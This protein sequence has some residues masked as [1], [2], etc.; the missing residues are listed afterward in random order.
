M[1]LFRRDDGTHV[2]MNLDIHEL[3]E[4]VVANRIVLDD[5]TEAVRDQAEELR[6]E[7]KAHDRTQRRKL[8]KW[9]MTSW[10]AAINPEDVDKTREYD[11]AH[12]VPTDYNKH[13]EPIFTSQKHRANYCRVH[14]L[15]DRNAGYGDPAPRNR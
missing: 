8:A 13:G 1:Q 2:E 3:S 9:P 6:R 10:S 15:Y 14:E 11:R 7:F 5:G 4:R 12:G